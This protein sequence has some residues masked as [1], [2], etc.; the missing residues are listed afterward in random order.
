MAGTLCAAE[1]KNPANYYNTEERI[2][3]TRPDPASERFFGI[4]GTTGIK[5]RIYPGVVLKVETLMPGSPCEGKFAKDEILT[6][7]NGI[8]LKGRDPFVAMGNALTK[9]EATDGKMVFD[10]TSADGKTQRKET[11]TIPVLGAY[12]KTW[13][14]DCPKSK[15]IIDEAAA[16]YADPQKFNARDIPGALGCLF[17]LSTGDDKYLPRVKAYFDAFPKDV[18]AIGVSTWSNGYNG[19]ACGEYYLRSGDKSVLPILQYYCDDAK[20]HQIYGCGWSHY[21]TKSIDPGYM[22]GVLHAA[23]VQVITTLLLGKECGVNVDEK[24]LLGALLHV[25]R[26]AGHGGVPYGNHRGEG[27]LGSN[28]KDSM[29]AA[30][31]QIAAGASGDTTIYQKASKYMVLGTIDSYSSMVMGHGDEGRS[32]GIWRSITTSYLMKEKPDLFRESMDRLT[33]W[34]DLSREP[35]GSIGV[36]TL[37]FMNGSP[38]GHSG[39][40]M[41]LSFTAPLRTLRITGAPKTKFSQEYTL[42]TNLWGTEADLAFLSLEHNP[43]YLEYGPEEPTHVPYWALGGAYHQPKK[44][45]KTLPRE[46]ILKNVYHRQFMIRTQACKALRANDAFDELEKLLEDP[47]PRVRRAALDGMIDYN[48]F[49]CIGNNPIPTDKFTPAMV[50][51]ITKML[52]DPKESWWV[53]DGA[54]LALKFAPAKDIQQNYKLIEPWTKHSDWWLRQSSF[55]ALSG[56]EKDDAQYVK[57]LPKL[58]QMATSEYHA[59]PREWMMQ[60]LNAVLQ[61][62]KP[63]SET[64]KLI[65]AAL[66]KGV[67]T[68][69]IKSGDLGVSAWN[70]TETLKLCLQNDPNLA[71]ALATALRLRF[72]DL[73]TNDIV[74]IAADPGGFSAVLEKLDAKQRKELEDILFTVYRP[75]LI[76]R[77]NAKDYEEEGHKPGMV[78]AIVSLTNLKEK[79]AVPGPDPA[80]FASPP[81]ISGT[82]DIVMK[83]TP[84]RGDFEPIEYFFDETSGNPGGADSGWTTHPV[85]T[86]TSLEPGTSYT[87][88]VKMRNAL[89]QEGNASLPL[90]VTTPAAKFT[91]VPIPNGGF[92]TIYKPGQTT[93]TGTISGYTTG[94]GPATTLSSGG[95]Y[96]FSDNTSG[97]LADVPDWIGYDRDG[98]IKYGGTGPWGTQNSN[99]QGFLSA[100]GMKA[101]GNSFSCNGAGWACREGALIV[102]AV[103]IGKIQGK[104]TYVLVGYAAG[105][106]TPFVLRLLADGVEV[107]P[108]SA[109]DPQ[110]VGGWQKFSRTYAPA[111]LA[112]HVG[113]EITIVC[114]LGRDAKGTQTA[115]DELSLRYFIVP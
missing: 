52:S 101:G 2:Y 18:K 104:A 106:A 53:I 14:L 69:K 68:G 80:T 54:L 74:G 50:K 92:D 23:S 76:K 107:T 41:G 102:S 44:D 96:N 12:S 103:S 109:I 24:T 111:D 21:G 20:E 70:I 114:G 86:D 4:I 84:G 13:P 35:G 75:E 66:R 67:D 48:Y 95:N 72:R 82:L 9:A 94:V 37:N 93:I 28:G 71:P 105:S 49:F 27:G 11:V 55:L 56:L 40:G 90:S 10:V 99:L 85:Y 83:A 8:A 59:M 33:W 58:L 63:E 97:I 61:Q 79:V 77:L 5:A 29:A 91:A 7:I 25:Y 17:L 39:P 73:R 57:I 22:G 3:S 65:I 31:M 87:Y 51:S 1:Q 98:W 64:G 108:T 81:S 42:P 88:T 43:K 89:G 15:R 110:L 113:K 6:G 46:V 38:V 45:L 26:F 62:K 112:K 47:D 60:H 115:M 34:H 36:A 100:G 19:I 32:D 30:A 16:F 78:S